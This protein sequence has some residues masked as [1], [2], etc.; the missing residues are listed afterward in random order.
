MLTTPLLALGSLALALCPAPQEAPARFGDAAAKQAQIGADGHG[1]V[2]RATAWLAGSQEQSGGWAFDGGGDSPSL[3]ASGMALLAL[4]ADGN[5][6]KHGAHAAS[7]ERAAAWLVANATDEAASRPKGIALYA[8][9]ELHA[10]DPGAVPVAALKQLA[11]D[12]ADECMVNG[13]W[14]AYDEPQVD[15]MATVWAVAGLTEAQRAGIA[16]DPKVLKRTRRWL[17]GLVS[18]TGSA[19]LETNSGAEEHGAAVLLVPRLLLDE[20]VDEAPYLMRQAKRLTRKKAAPDWEQEDFEYWYAAVSGLYLAA[21]PNRY[22][23][24]RSKDAKETQE[25]LAAAAKAFHAQVRELLLERQFAGGPGD[26]TWEGFGWAPEQG[27]V[28]STAMAVLMLAAPYRLAG[29]VPEAVS[30]DAPLP[31]KLANREKARKRLSSAGGKGTEESLERAIAWLVDNQS[32]SGSWQRDDTTHPVGT[33]ALALLA[34]IG[35]GHTPVGGAHQAKVVQGLVWLRAQQ[36]ATTGRVGAGPLEPYIYDHAVATIV[37][38]EAYGYERT[39]EARA[40]LQRAVEF[41]QSARNPYGAWR[42]RVPPTGDNDTSVTTWMMIALL[43]AR[44]VGLQIDEA[45]LENARAF[46]D[47]VTD[48]VSGR[49]GYRTRGGRSAR[50]QGTME[51]FP[52]EK[53]EALTAAA[54]MGRVFTFD[55]REPDKNTEALWELQ[56]NLLQKRLPEWNERD[57]SID[58]YY[59]YHGTYAMFQLGGKPWKAW[60]TALKEALTTSQRQDGAAGG[61]WDPECAWGFVGGRVYSTA[62]CALMLE[63]YFR[64]P[65]VLKRPR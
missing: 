6:T 55:E 51:S 59:W 63:V 54:L 3:P 32:P 20:K 1:A 46:Y 47:E 22:E 44:D 24:P 7:V 48:P 26:G 9:S 30:P 28:R 14:P 10:L 53:S 58:L 29:G 42:Y 18:E 62:L 52:V 43:A 64:Y 12:L 38:A 19:A 8:L 11:D 5:T 17:E 33:S 4:L 34:L 16:V 15:A 50:A 49:S 23:A 39:P 36:N 40:A 61:S 57:G 60:N 37:L 2:L 35:D 41:C 21:Q 65:Q 56:S 27:A 25:E 13:G 45:A 31:T